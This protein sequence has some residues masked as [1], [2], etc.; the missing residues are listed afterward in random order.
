[1]Q[2]TGERVVLRDELRQSD[3]EIWFRWLNLEQWQYYDEPDA[4]FRP[5]SR[6][7]A[8][9]MWIYWRSPAPS[10]HRLYIDTREGRFIGWVNSYGFD[11]ESRSLFVGIDLPEEDTW[12]KGYGTEALRL[13]ID[14]L[15]RTMEL[16]EIKTATWTGNRRMMRCAEK[17]GFPEAV[18][19]PH[20]AA[21]SVRGEPLERAE[22]SMS[23]A[24]WAAQAA[25]NH[26]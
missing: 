19:M 23:R 20:R 16:E 1:M 8:E 17:C 6:E 12:G 14:Y 21:L 5:V 9:G 18:R 3:K 2:I 13:W 26:K 24:A 11:P 25:T 4:P 15:F 10:S 7:A 22:F